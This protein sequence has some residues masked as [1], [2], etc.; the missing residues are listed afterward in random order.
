MT[1]RFDRLLDGPIR[2]LLDGADALIVSEPQNVFLVADVVPPTLRLL[3]ERLLMP[4]FHT[5][6]EPFWVIAD[7]TRDVI[8]RQSRHISD[9]VVYTEYRQ[10]PI[11]ALVEALRERGLPN[12]RILV[13]KNHLS[14]G[15]YEELA[16]SLPGVTIDDATP[17]LHEMRAIKSP[18]EQ[19]QL[20]DRANATLRA[21]A[22]CYAETSIGDT[23]VEIRQR[24]IQKL[25]A[26]G[27]D[28]LEFVTLARGRG[29]ILNGVAGDT[30][31]QRGDMLRV[32][33]GGT[34]G[35]WRS[36]IHRTAVAGTPSTRLR[37]AWHRNRDVHYAAMDT[38]RP[39]RPVSETY[40]VCARE[41]ERRGMHCDMP[42]IGHSLGVGQ[43]EFPVLTPFAEGEY[44]SGMVIMLEPMGKDPD[45]GGFSI[46]DM[47]LITDDDPVV[48]SD[49]VGT[50]E[51][52]VIG[53]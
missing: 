22:E 6:A 31:L 45:L 27:F 25:F 8:R 52:I 20:Q 38:L 48:L 11:E 28:T 29:D 10:S 23:E 14:A 3:P 24:A 26:H 4:V 46:E 7:I 30:P 5:S 36:D 17:A 51:M 9:L 49:A 37:D 13:E 21:L 44:E 12:R 32:D 19:R 35:G 15:Y 16:R 42:F 33:M 39:G 34:M 50:E 53:E 47:V 1:T 41:Y 40:A 2:R 43:H 18:E